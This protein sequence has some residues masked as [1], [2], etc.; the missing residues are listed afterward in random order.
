MVTW[1]AW[2]PN[3]NLLI[4]FSGVELNVGTP[5]SQDTKHNIPRGN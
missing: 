4:S 5:G 2:L 3:L 1:P